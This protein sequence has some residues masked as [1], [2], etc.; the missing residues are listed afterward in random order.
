MRGK[1]LFALVLLS[2]VIA[3]AQKK[4]FSIVELPSQ[5]KVEVRY[6][7]KLLT[8]YCYFDSTEKPV[9]FPI[10]TI[11]GITVTRGYPIIPRQGERADHPHQVGLWMA[12]ESVNGID[13]WNNSFAIPPERKSNYGSIKNVRILEHEAGEKTS[14]LKTLSQ[15]VDHSGKVQLEETTIFNFEISGTTF[16]IDR[17][18][19]WSALMDVEF[20]DVK[21]GLLGMRLA[22]ELEMPSSQQ[23][24][25]IGIDR[26][27]HGP[28][29][30]NNDG[31]TGMYH[32]KEG[33]AGD[34]TWGKRSEWT[35]ITGQKDNNTITIGII[36]HRDNIGHPT[37]WHARGYGLFAANP[38]GQKVFS[39]GR[40]ELNL[41]MKRGDKLTFKYRIV[42]HEGE[43]FG[44]DDMETLKDTFF[45]K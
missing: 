38:L 15:W 19:M 26:K 33:L 17:T 9:L 43:N 14:S 4:G 18:A 27:I 36:D 6:N 41:R 2:T 10:K 44:D 42:I 5:L 11:S 45:V 39:N 8:S 20:R 25:F 29:R 12:Y 37:Y 7:D 40:Q 22:R 3:C 13:F 24:Q 16:I 23:D 32:N 21:D 35:Y 28:A 34:S 30:I 1:L 31:V